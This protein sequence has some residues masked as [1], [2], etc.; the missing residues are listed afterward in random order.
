[1][2]LTEKQSRALKAYEQTKEFA[3]NCIALATLAELGCKTEGA[4]C[5]GEFA[6][7]LVRNCGVSP[8]QGIELA[9]GYCD[10]LVRA[11]V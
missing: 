8:K 11:E 7:D 5:L 1:M 4:N 10:V 6:Y 9:L 3:V 2:R